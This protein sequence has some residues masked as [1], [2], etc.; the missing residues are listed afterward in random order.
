MRFFELHPAPWKVV[1][2]GSGKIWLPIIADANGKTVT[3]TK[4]F[5]K[6]IIKAIND[7]NLPTPPEAT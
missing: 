7:T 4:Q 1:N 6:A 5:Y 2:M 3:P